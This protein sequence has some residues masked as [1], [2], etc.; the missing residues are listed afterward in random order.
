MRQ[1]VEDE[2]NALVVAS[3]TAGPEAVAGPPGRRA[4]PRG[5]ADLAIKLAGVLAVLVVLELCSRFGLLPR[6]WFP[7]VSEMYAELFRLA[8]Q[9]PL[10]VEVGR[11]LRAWA[12]GIGLATLLAVPAGV[13][14]GSSAVAYRM[15]RIVIEFCRPIPSVALIPLA[16]LVYGTGLEMK[17][18]LIAF[19]TF[20]PLLFQTVY[21]VQDVDPVARDTARAYGLG[22][23]ARFWVITI[24]S[25]APYIATGLR[26]ASSIG[27]VLAVTSELVGGATGLGRAIV[28]AQSAG[29]ITLMYALI[30]TTGLLGW[31]LNAVFA[32][33]ERKALRWHPAQRQEVAR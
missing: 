24:P 29:Q 12:V 27:L 20:W 9:Q 13:A 32:A 21:G 7:P 18:F 10:W 16:V 15:S 6:R 3:D 17:V 1:A 26:I 8:A 30:I 22:A 33:V 4:G 25:A 28:V 14:L 5:A 31:A 23:A 2:G 11:T 19:A